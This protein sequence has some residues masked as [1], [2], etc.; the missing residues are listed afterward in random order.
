MPTR[1]GCR[2]RWGSGRHYN[3]QL[4]QAVRRLR[5]NAGVLNLRRNMANPYFDSRYQ[6]RVCRSQWRR[7]RRLDSPGRGPVKNS[8]STVPLLAALL[9]E[10][11][12]PSWLIAAACPSPPELAVKMPGV[13][14]VTGT[15]NAGDVFPWYSPG[16]SCYSPRRQTARWR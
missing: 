16:P 1:M 8:V 4:H 11:K 13:V 10:L 2:G 7:P 3:V 12:V 15:S 6:L 9:A 5:S 14:S